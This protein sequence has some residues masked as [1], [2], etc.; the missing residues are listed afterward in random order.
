MVKDSVGVSV[1]GI[2]QDKGSRNSNTG[3]NEEDHRI[4]LFNRKDVESKVSTDLS[5]LSL[6][7]L[8]IYTSVN[9]LQFQSKDD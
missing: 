4:S 5:P 6:S 9:I 1:V 7:V 3:P 8:V 2:I